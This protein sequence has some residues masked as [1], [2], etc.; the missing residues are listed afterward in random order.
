MPSVRSAASAICTSARK[1]S[2]LVRSRRCG[3]T[4]TSGYGTAF[5]CGRAVTEFVGHPSSYDIAA[6][7]AREMHLPTVYK[8]MRGGDPRP[9]KQSLPSLL[10][11]HTSPI[12]GHSMS[13]PLGG[14]SRT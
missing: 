1:Q 4:T 8:A 7:L 12:M 5:E 10:A 6:E 3:T 11:V 9:L 2:R 13:E 14:V